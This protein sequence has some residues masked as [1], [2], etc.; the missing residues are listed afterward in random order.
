MTEVNDK[1]INAEK[2]AVADAIEGAHNGESN[3]KI[4]ML[5]RLRLIADSSSCDILARDCRSHGKGKPQFIR[6]NRHKLQWPSRESV[7]R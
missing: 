4:N 2:A 1:G 3:I 7:V 5:L 6:S